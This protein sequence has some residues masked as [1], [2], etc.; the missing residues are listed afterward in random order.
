M[1]VIGEKING[2]RKAVAAAIKQRD[3]AFIQDLAKRQVEAG[4]AYLDVNAGT[5]PEREVE[6]M[7]WLIKTIQQVSETPLCLDSANPEALEAGLKIVR[8]KPMINS[9]NGESARIERILPLACRYQT[10]LIVLAMDDKGVPKSV[11]DRLVIIG[12]LIQMTRNGGLA[13][14][15]L[16]IDPLIMTISTDTQNGN[17]ALETMRRVKKDFPEAHLTGGMSNI[18]FGAPARSIV[19]QAFMGLAIYSGLDSA[20]MDPE[21]R[22]LRGVISATEM[23][24]GKDPYCR[25]YNQAYRSGK[26]GGA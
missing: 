3:A 16:Y 20:I 18:S 10:E 1:I 26:I 8:D 13:D 12:R 7:V 23:L 24:M 14:E 2:T 9:L 4:A 19:N 11:E 25:Q 21:D 5:H 17:V 6:D 15:K 22:P